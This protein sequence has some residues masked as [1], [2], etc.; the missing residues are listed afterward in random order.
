[1]VIRMM[2]FSNVRNALRVSVS[3]HGK[4]NELPFLDGLRAIAALIVVFSHMSLAG[5]FRLGPFDAAGIGKTGVYLFFVLSGFLLSRAIAL[6]GRSFFAPKSIWS[7][8]ARRFLRIYPLFVVYLLL[9]LSTTAIRW[10]SGLETIV[11]PFHLGPTAFLAHLLLL[12]GYGVT[13]S[14][15]V[16]FKYYFLLPVVALI[17]WA[18]MRRSV[19]VALLLTAAGVIAALMFWPG[20][21][22]SKNDARLGFYLPS[23]FIGS[24]LGVLDANLGKLKASGWAK[25]IYAVAAAIAALGWAALIPSL[26]AMLLRR[27]VAFNELHSAVLPFSLLWAVLLVSARQGAATLRQPLEWAP[28]RYI[29]VISFSLYLWHPVVVALFKLAMPA[30]P[31]SLGWLIVLPSAVALSH[32]SYCLIERPFLLIKPKLPATPSRVAQWGI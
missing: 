23:F 12:K 7:Y 8:A 9:A 29:G 31:P 20:H 5:V 3:G 1:M 4:N 21:Q 10:A 2:A 15:A 14:I 18:T 26:S 28:L 25:L 6:Q 22:M 19:S 17:L 11:V 13:W 32:L 16:E 24:F 27:P 30:C